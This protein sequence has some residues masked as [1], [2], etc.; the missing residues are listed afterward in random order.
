MCNSCG[1][2][3]YSSGHSNHRAGCPSDWGFV[4]TDN[5]RQVRAFHEGQ[6][7]A[8]A[9]RPELPSDSLSSTSYRL[10]FRRRKS[11]H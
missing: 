8:Q 9:G 2:E 11:G 1:A 4:G 7:D 10:G 3:G 5:G 6:A